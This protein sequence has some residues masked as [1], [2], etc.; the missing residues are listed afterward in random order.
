MWIYAAVAVLAFAIVSA[1]KLSEVYA[2]HLIVNTSSD[3]SKKLDLL[4]I[5]ESQ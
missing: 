3:L 1:P 2:K 4:K 5:L